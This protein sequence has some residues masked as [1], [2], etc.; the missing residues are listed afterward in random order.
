MDVHIDCKDSIVKSLL[1]KSYNDDEGETTM[2]DSSEP[3]A[4]KKFLEIKGHRM[5]YIDEGE[6]APIVFAH[7]NPTSSYLWR[8]IMPDCRG[9]GRLIACDMIWMGDSDQPPNS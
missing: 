6:G 9:L 3:F 8:N 7:G 2:T 5:A 1:F 4:P